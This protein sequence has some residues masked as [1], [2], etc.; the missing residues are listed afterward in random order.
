MRKF[1][2]THT[3]SAEICHVNRTQSTSYKGTR[4]LVLKFCWFWLFP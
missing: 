3:K 4:I 1:V 2:A